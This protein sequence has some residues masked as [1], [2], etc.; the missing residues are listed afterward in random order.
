MRD[1]DSLQSDIRRDWEISEVTAQANASAD[2]A[3][4]Y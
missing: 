1:R 4:L 3:F 2:L